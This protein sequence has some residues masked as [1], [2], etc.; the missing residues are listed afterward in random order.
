MTP[1]APR[2]S[3]TGLLFAA[4]AALLFASK[5]LFSKA[6]TA[7]GVDYV[8]ITAVRALLAVPLFA[9]LALWRGLRVHDAPRAALWRAALAG[10]LG[11]G[12]GSL[13][14]FRALE[15]IDVSVER[16]L[17]FTYPALIVAWQAIVRHRLPQPAML[18]ALAFT[19]G[20]ILLV[21]GGFDAALWRQ[22][23]AGAALVLGCAACMVCYFLL[24]ERSIRELG[25]NGFA[26][27]ALGAAA[28]FVLA[29]FFG[30]RPVSA[31]T[32]LGAHEWLLLVA[33]AVLC[34]FLPT[35]FQAG[36]I[37][38]LGAARGALAST[39]GPPAALLLG[40]A[41]LG[42]RPSAAQLLGTAL[43]VAGIVLVARGEVSPGE[44]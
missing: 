27:V 36:A 19:Y 41:L 15:M 3:G 23:L 4:C 5:G 33:L 31:L 37:Q 25:G 39:L 21:V 28:A 38:R 18:L 34:M 29:I 35:V 40:M 16:A 13:T 17:L 8:T 24:G 30:T 32:S 12:V 1:P 9:G 11:Y 10:V 2:H 22:N 20:G 44:T 7:R 14:D 26:V 42:E 43:I 6:L